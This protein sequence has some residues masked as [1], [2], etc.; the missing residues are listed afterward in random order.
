MTHSVGWMDNYDSWNNIA[1]SSRQNSEVKKRRMAWDLGSRE[2]EKGK[3]ISSSA[4]KLNHEHRPPPQLTPQRP[5]SCDMRDAAKLSIRREN[6]K[7]GHLLELSWPATVLLQYSICAF[8]PR[9][10]SIS[11]MSLADLCA[12]V[13]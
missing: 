8:P 13:G 1:V 4:T 11:L 2:E 7:I 6:N 10:A 5:S 3:G 12:V 9:G